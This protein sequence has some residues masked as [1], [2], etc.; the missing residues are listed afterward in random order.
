MQS[1]LALDFFSIQ[2][3][4]MTVSKVRAR[5]NRLGR[6]RHA[7]SNKKAKGRNK[8][9]IVDSLAVVYTP[10]P[11]S[12]LRTRCQDIPSKVSCTVGEG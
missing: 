11:S 8:K 5:T 4:Y 12:I 6:A 10:C 7:C 3:L 2:K 9:L 1:I